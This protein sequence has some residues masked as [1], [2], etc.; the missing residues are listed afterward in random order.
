MITLYYGDNKLKILRYHIKDES[1]YQ[2]PLLPEEGWHPD[3]VYRDDGVVG[4]D[5]QFNSN[6]NYN[7]LFKDESGAEADSQIHA[8][9]DILR[10]T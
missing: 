7:V 5:P 3:A 4:G 1:V 6:R 9:E 10:L 8:L 2:A